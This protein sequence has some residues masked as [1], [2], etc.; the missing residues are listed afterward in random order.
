[1][2]NSLTTSASLFGQAPGLATSAEVPKL[3]KD[4]QRSPEAIR[5]VAKQFESIF[6]HQVFKSMRATVP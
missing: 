1:M 5:E 3:D 6:I 2:S 4:G